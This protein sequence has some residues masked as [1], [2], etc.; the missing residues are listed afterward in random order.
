MSR[1]KVHVRN[2]DGSSV[3]IERE[4]D[5]QTSHAVL[6]SLLS[7]LATGPPASRYPVDPGVAVRIPDV[8]TRALAAGDFVQDGTI[9]LYTTAAPGSSVLGHDGAL[10][11]PASRGVSANLLEW[12]V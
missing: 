1:E 12:K 2:V 5:Q 10:G 7:G 9:D 8:T 4:V 6:E 3:T 11:Q